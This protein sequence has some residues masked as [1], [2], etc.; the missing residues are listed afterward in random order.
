MLPFLLTYVLVPFSTCFLV[1]GKSS[2]PICMSFIFIEPM[3]HQEVSE[4]MSSAFNSTRSVSFDWKT[5]FQLEHFEPPSV[6]CS[7]ESAHLTRCDASAQH[8][9]FARNHLVSAAYLINVLNIAHNND[10]L[11][12]IVAL[13]SRGTWHSRKSR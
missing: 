5:Q 10:R 8:L 6:N 13:Y 7:I 1:L 12:F 9:A 11:N 2:G 4:I 3:T